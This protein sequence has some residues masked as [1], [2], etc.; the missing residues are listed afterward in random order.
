MSNYIDFYEIM[1]TYAAKNFEKH[2]NLFKQ[3]F[4]LYP[5]YVLCNISVLEC[6]HRCVN[7]LI[8]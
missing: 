5:T 7:W 1:C 8:F 2:K 3:L 6:S 4:L